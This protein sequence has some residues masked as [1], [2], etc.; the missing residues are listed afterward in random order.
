MYYLHLHS[1]M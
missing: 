1:K